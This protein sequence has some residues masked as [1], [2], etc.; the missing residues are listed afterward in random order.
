VQLDP[1][2][3]SMLDVRRAH[4]YL[5]Q[6]FDKENIDTFWGTADEFMTQLTAEIQAGG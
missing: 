1:A 3:E 2:E 5:E 6:Y 4:E